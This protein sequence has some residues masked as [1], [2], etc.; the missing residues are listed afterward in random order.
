MGNVQGKSGEKKPKT[1]MQVI[2]FVAANY[3]LTQSFTDLVALTEKEYCDKLII[4]TSDVLDKYLTKT[5]VDFLA[6]K[7]KQG[8]AINEMD[9]DEL[10]YLRKDNIEDLG[11]K[12]PTSKKRKCIGIAKYYIKIAHIFGAILTT[13][14]PTYIYKEKDG[15]SRTVSF[16]E[17][18]TIPQDADI[19][20]NKLNLCSERVNALVNGRSF[21]M[22]D[23]SQPIKIKPN[24][25]QMNINK[26]KTRE[27]EEKVVKTLGDE[28]GISELDNLYN[29]IYNYETGKFTGMSEGMRETYNKDIKT[30]Y[31]AFTGN[32]EMPENIKSFSQI[33]LRDFSSL[34]G[35]Q[36]KPN[37]QY[38]QE[39]EGTQKD[40]LFVD[41]ANHVREMMES[42][43]KGKN[44]LVEIFDQLFVFAV[45]PSTKKAE[46][47]INPKLTDDMLNKFV[48]DTQN[49]IINL[50]TTCEENFIKGLQIFEQIIDEQLKMRE[51]KVEL[52][53]EIV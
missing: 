6:Q 41:Y 8:V 14:N 20:L 37:N 2:N 46:I 18:N 50:Y 27:T 30:M 38:L 5:D 53:N 25:C 7:M 16:S 13:I 23:T 33:P 39:Y 29:D 36:G 12:N 42:S 32:E 47:T 43:E 1:L 3:I 34:S 31:T 24:F 35:C 21:S 11:I 22:S 17:K 49:S 15:T 26:E 48:K 9:H 19:K 10:M 52:Q 51:S 45:N 44:A 40:K 4:I 28:P